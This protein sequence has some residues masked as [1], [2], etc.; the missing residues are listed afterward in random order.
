MS[1]VLLSRELLCEELLTPCTIT[2]RDKGGGCSLPSLRLDVAVVVRVV[3]DVLIA[4]EQVAVVLHLVP[5]EAVTGGVL[6]AGDLK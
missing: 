3:I 2:S 5:V 4:G 6:G 1:K